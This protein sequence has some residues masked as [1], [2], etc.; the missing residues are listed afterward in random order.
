MTRS[1]LLEKVPLS[2]VSATS[3]GEEGVTGPRSIAFR[4]RSD[5]P[6]STVARDFTITLYKSCEAASLL[7][8]VGAES[9]LQV[10]I[11]QINQ[12]AGSPLVEFVVK[13]HIKD[14]QDFIGQL[15]T[16]AFVNARS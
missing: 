7:K 12:L 2:D 16:I 14:L 13:K 10:V 15:R 6:G 3:T 1:L 9:S 4:T 8:A 11:Q 5:A